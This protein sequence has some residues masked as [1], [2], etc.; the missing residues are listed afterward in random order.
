MLHKSVRLVGLA[1]YAGKYFSMCR[2]TYLRT[3]LTILITTSEVAWSVVSLRIV[4]LACLYVND[5]ITFE[6]LDAGNP[7]WGLRLLYYEGY[8]FKVKITGA[9]NHDIL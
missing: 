2:P 6:S 8:L 4:W 5:T 1:V 3:K 9:K 7:F